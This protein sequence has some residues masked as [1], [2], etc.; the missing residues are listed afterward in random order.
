[1]TWLAAVLLILALLLWN[2]VKHNPADSHSLK[3]LLIQHALMS[4]MCK[5]GARVKKKLYNISNNLR[6]HQEKL[7]LDIVRKNE[8]TK[9]GEKYEF[10][11]IYNRYDYVSRTPLMTY[12]D[13]HG[14]INEIVDGEQ[15]VL[16]KSKL[17]LFCRGATIILT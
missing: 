13:M 9:Y 5:V 3:T 17:Y 14:Y 1:M 4:I 16:L 10:V 6:N 12:P 8:D 2:M 15:E 11:K 7:L